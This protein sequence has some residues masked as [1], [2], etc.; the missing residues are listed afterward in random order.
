M[1][2][3]KIWDE[4]PHQHVGETKLLDA[5]VQQVAG[6]SKADVREDDE[7]GVAVLV[8][9]ARGIEVVDT[10][11][12]SVCLALA[13]TLTLAFVVVVSRNIAQKVE[14]PSEKLLCNKVDGGHNRGLLTKLGKSMCSR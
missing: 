8:K 7:L 10:V 5:L 14:D 4:V 13:P 9:W 6:D 3:P 2:D 12:P 1:I 11:K